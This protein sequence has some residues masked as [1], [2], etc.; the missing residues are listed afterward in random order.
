[1]PLVVC[2]CNCGSSDQMAR[3]FLQ[4]NGYK[5]WLSIPISKGKEKSLAVL[6]NIPQYPE[7]DMLRSYLQKVSKYVVILGWNEN[8]C[9][10]TDISHNAAKSRIEGEVIVE[11]FA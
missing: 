7:V 4:K 8:G 11:T 3:G 2:T 10:W 6:Y 5:D 9:R 1:M